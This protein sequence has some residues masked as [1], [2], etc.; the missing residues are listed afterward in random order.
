MKPNIESYLLLGTEG[1]DEEFQSRQ[2]VFR[3][4]FETATSEIQV[5]ILS[6]QTYLLDG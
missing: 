2:S 5:R 4:R 3:P 6:V 1:N